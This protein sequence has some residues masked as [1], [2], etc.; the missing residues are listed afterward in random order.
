MGKYAKEEDSMNGNKRFFESLSAICSRPHVEEV[1]PLRNEIKV[2]ITYRLPHADTR[3]PANMI[4][5]RD[6]TGKY[7]KPH[8][9]PHIT[10]CGQLESVL[11]QYVKDGWT[12]THNGNTHIGEKNGIQNIYTVEN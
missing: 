5:H 10:T 2:F 9:I 11:E 1:K 3:F 8:H 7:T 4:S 12:V 6:S